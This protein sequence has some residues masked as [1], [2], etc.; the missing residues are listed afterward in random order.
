MA[1]LQIL[2]SDNGTTMCLRY[3]VFLVI[4]RNYITADDVIVT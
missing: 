3:K 2:R 4:G 1:K